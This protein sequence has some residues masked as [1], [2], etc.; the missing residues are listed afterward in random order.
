MAERPRPQETGTLGESAPSDA[1]GELQQVLQDVL[2]NFQHQS[3]TSHD[4]H[5]ITIRPEDIVDVCRIAKEE[6]RLAFKLLLCLAA[7]DYQEYFPDR[8][9]PPVLRARV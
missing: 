5:E 3:A 9:R 7:V 4:I 1:V 8:V 2:K 6:P